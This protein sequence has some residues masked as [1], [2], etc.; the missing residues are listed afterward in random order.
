MHKTVTLY[1]LRNIESWFK[2]VLYVKHINEK[3]F[4]REEK[5]GTNENGGLRWCLGD[6]SLFSYIDLD[7]CNTSTQLNTSILNNKKKIPNA[8]SCLQQRILCVE[9]W[10]FCYI[11]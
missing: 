5:D 1:Q 10:P 11:V 9:G 2:Y 8:V 4:W 7:I 3:D 6:S